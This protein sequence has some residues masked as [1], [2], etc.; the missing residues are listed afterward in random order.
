MKNRLIGCVI[1]LA[2]FAADQWSKNFVTR[3]LGIDEIGDAME[4]VPFFDLRFTR[5]FGVSLGMFEAT[6][7]EMRWGLVL[8]TALIA[9]VVTVWMLREK[10][11]GD[12]IAL[13]FIL[14]G[15]LGNIKDR[16]ELGYVVDFADLHFGDFRPF[17]IFNV[18]D[19]AITIG[20]LIVLARA[21]FMRDNDDQ[22]VDDLMNTKAA[23]AAE[24][25]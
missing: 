4:I 18:A 25:K 23:D 8:V 6:S 20:V 10:L 11:L 13:S 2:I 15:A 9:L 14:G 19:A 16:Y 22:E 21:F 17:L 5:N 1:A 3:T 7:P 24:S 12:I